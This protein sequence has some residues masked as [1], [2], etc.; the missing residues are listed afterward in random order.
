MNIKH[1]S[2]AFFQGLVPIFFLTL[3]WQTRIDPFSRY[4]VYDYLIPFVYLSDILLITLLI[5]TTINKP[6]W[7]IQ[8][9]KQNKWLGIGWGT[10]LVVAFIGIISAIHPIGALYKF[11][12]LLL[13]CLFV[14]WIIEISARWSINRILSIVGV[15]LAPLAIVGWIE[16]LNG[17]SLGLQL[18]GEW[19]FTVQTP[20]VAKTILFGHEWLRAYSV[21]PHPNVYGGVMAAF[22]LIFIHRALSARIKN[23]LLLFRIFLIFSVIFI[24][25]V[26]VSFSRSALIGLCVGSLLYVPL[27]IQIIRRRQLALFE[28]VSGGIVF[29]GI[30]AVLVSRIIALFG[31]DY[32]SFLRRQGLNTIAV[33]MWLDSMWVGVGLSQF[34]SKLDSYWHALGFARYVQP[35]HNIFLLILVETGIIGFVSFWLGIIMSIVKKR[36][37]VILPL[38]SLFILIGI[39]GMI[40]HYWWTLQSGMLMLFLTFGLSLSTIT[41]DKR[42]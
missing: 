11:A 41:I 9:I 33:N 12:K 6:N 34:I 30:S 7:L 22:G 1:V 10:F 39:T 35:V 42:E 24:V 25:S 32:L 4:E 15:G 2:T 23:D 16:F 28:V 17:Q 21:F 8:Q 20:G 14:F 40:D 31:W 27:M 38:Y 37:T 18:I 3:F 36:S 13:Y 19:R 5:L 26:M 29:I